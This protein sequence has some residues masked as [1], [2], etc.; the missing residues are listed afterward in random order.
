MAPLA[1]A[2]HEMTH[3]KLRAMLIYHIHSSGA[4]LM[5]W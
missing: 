4:E 1:M 3:F 5:F 2:Y